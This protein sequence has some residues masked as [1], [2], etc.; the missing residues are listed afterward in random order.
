ME[1]VQEIKRLSEV[2]SKC[3]DL[4]EEEVVHTVVKGIQKKIMML[5]KEET[6][7]RADLCIERDGRSL[8]AEIYQEVCSRQP[9]L[10]ATLLRLRKEIEDPQ[11]RLETFIQVALISLYS[12]GNILER[13]SRYKDII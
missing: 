1:V 7:L 11:K 6:R 2:Y 8:T 10:S 5:N 12:N 3:V 4:D 13:T 9:G